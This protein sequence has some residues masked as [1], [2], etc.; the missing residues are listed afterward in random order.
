MNSKN[1]SLLVPWMLLECACLS[2]S[3]PRQERRVV[4]MC[5]FEL[6]I[7]ALDGA[8]DDMIRRKDCIARSN[9]IG[10]WS[11]HIWYIKYR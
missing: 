1:T 10:V 3:R 6:I 11:R 4:G 7:V 8:V 9:E 5:A 2:R